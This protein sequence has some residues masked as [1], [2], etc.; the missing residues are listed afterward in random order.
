MSALEDILDWCRRN[1]LYTLVIYDKIIPALEELA[2][3]D[4]RISEL[5]AIIIEA[6]AQYNIDTFPAEDKIQSAELALVRCSS[7][8][9][10]AMRENGKLRTDLARLQKGMEE[11]RQ[12]M[13][14]MPLRTQKQVEWLKE[15]GGEP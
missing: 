13:N 8:G 15:Y 2:S 9:A 1:S 3:K 14:D 7:M 11:A 6:D 5:E 10:E 12:A 4:A